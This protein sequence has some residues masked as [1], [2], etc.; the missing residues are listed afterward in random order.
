[1]YLR[2]LLR[3]SYKNA[4]RSALGTTPCKHGSKFLSNFIAFLMLMLMNAHASAASLPHQGASVQFHTVGLARHVLEGLMVPV[5]SGVRVN[6]IGFR[7]LPT[8]SWN[9]KDPPFM[10]TP[11]FRGWDV[12]MQMLRNNQAQIAAHLPRREARNSTQEYLAQ[13]SIALR[14]CLHSSP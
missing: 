13:M 10:K 4:A 6:I 9:T 3:T 14:Q 8:T 11:G 12:G 1:M 5:V 7:A 2:M